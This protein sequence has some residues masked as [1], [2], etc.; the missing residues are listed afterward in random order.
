M[1]FVN[2][3]LGEKLGETCLR[4]SWYI[5][6]I[7][8]IQSDAFDDSLSLYDIALNFQENGYHE[9]LDLITLHIA[10]ITTNSKWRSGQES[11]FMEFTLMYLYRYR[12][13]FWTVYWH[14]MTIFLTNLFQKY[15]QI[16]S[17]YLPAYRCIAGEIKAI[18]SGYIVSVALYPDA[19]NYDTFAMRIA[20]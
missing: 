11:C 15:N 2:D 5:T 4:K 12:N 7:L 6:Y 3:G 13:I 17:S 18:R 1:G 20:T 8:E 19:W 10:W 16:I 14:I 9:V